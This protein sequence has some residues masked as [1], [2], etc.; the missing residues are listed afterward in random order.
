[1]KM[2]VKYLHLQKEKRFSLSKNQQK[3][4]LLSG[5]RQIMWTG[6]DNRKYKYQNMSTFFNNKLRPTQKSKSDI[7]KIP[8][9]FVLSMIHNA[10]NKCI[11]EATTIEIYRRSYRG[12]YDHY[13]IQKAV[14]EALNTGKEVTIPPP[15]E[16]SVDKNNIHD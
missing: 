8:K 16:C 12:M 5:N 2:V 14:L 15:S 3:L 11:L 13:L 9:G 10:I 4:K 6:K 1:M 7:D